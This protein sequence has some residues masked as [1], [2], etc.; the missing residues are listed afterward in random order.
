M[1]APGAASSPARVAVVGA[2]GRMGE[3]V[4]AAI[5]AEPE[6]VLGAALEA[7]G[8]PALG[9][10]LEGGVVLS[11]D[12]AAALGAC[13]LAIVFATPAS[14]LEVLRV[15]AEQQVPC[16]VGTTGFEPAEEAELRSLAGKI[17][18]VHAANFSVAVNVLFHLAHQAAK[19]LGEDFDAEIVELHHSAKV[20]A[21][22]G[23]ALALGAAV[24]EGR[25][26]S[27]P[28]RAVLE[29]SGITGERPPGAIGIQT[30]R[31]G[32]NPGEHTLYFVSR[33]ERL[34]LAHRSSTRDHFARGSVRAALWARGR[35]PG[36]YDMQQV[37]GLPDR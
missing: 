23:T 6:V 28:E 16:A 37:L 11:D 19:L 36:L 22:S 21:P 35:A 10:E 34:E 14:T 7:P 12:A 5:E 4:R 30:L 25:G 3:R 13:D 9:R 17:P 29:R 2:L 26:E 27:L 24:A 20:D 1:S 31:G 18:I 33:G 32:D 8:H 15:A